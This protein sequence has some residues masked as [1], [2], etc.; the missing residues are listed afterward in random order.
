MAHQFDCYEQAAETQLLDI[1]NA[2]CWPDYCESLSEE[3]IMLLIVLFMILFALAIGGGEWG[4]KRFGYWGWSPAA[5]ILMVAV[6]LVFTGHLS[7]Q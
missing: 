7:W 1:S 3:D 6:F 5:F 4:S 2:H